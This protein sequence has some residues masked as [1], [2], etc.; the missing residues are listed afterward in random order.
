M[1]TVEKNGNKISALTLGTVQLGIPYG[2]NNKSGMPSR[3]LSGKILDTALNLGITA[4]DTAKAYGVSET[5]VGD[6]F[7]KSSKEKT[8]ITKIRFTDEAPEQ[9][10]DKVRGDVLDSLEKL[11]ISKLHVLLLHVETYVETYGDALK[12]ALAAVKEEGLVD[13]VGIS[14]SDKTHLLEYTIDPLFTAVQIPMNMLDCEEIRNGSLKILSERGIS[15]Y[16]RSLYLQGLFFKDPD[17]LP[18]KIKSAKPI[19]AELSALAKKEGVSMAEMALSYIRD[20]E[21]ITSLVIGAETPE[22]LSETVAAFSAPELSL[23]TR[24]RIE[25]LAAAVEPIV[26]RPWEW[27]K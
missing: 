15:V 14:F 2:I 25:E 21:G 24:E 8:L 16:V 3:E 23:S 12:A 27:N 17:T 18:E 7:K 26:I 20:A 11:G 10:K 13:E 1:K 6:Y 22:Q 4:F 5:V 19:L 9:L